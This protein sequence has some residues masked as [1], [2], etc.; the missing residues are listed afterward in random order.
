MLPE[1]CSAKSPPL[2]FSCHVRGSG[3][4]LL[5]RDR[6][7]AKTTMP[8]SQLASH[9]GQSLARP[10]GTPCFGRVGSTEP[11]TGHPTDLDHLGDEVPRPQA[12]AA[13]SR[14]SAE[15]SPPFTRSRLPGAPG[16]NA[17]S[18]PW[19]RSSSAQ[20]DCEWP[21]RDGRMCLLAQAPQSRTR[22]DDGRVPSGARRESR[23]KWTDARGLPSTGVQLTLCAVLMP[24]ARASTSGAQPA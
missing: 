23:I 4:V 21:R 3:H 6:R 13:A 12:T 2:A 16:R 18:R 11:G 10:R 20:A 5:F 14:G 1:A 24:L 7:P 19:P 22:P 15:R 17:F 8:E 9:P